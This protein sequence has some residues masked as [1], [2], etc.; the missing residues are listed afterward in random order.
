M[1]ALQQSLLAQFPQVVF[2]RLL[3]R[4]REDGEKPLL[5]V[6][7]ER[8]AVGNFLAAPDRFFLVGEEFIDL[9]GTTNVELIAG[10]LETVGIG[11]QAARVDAQKHVVGDGVGLVQ[12][13]SVAGGHQ[14]QPEAVGDVDGPLGTLLLDGQTVVLDLDVII[15]AKELVEPLGDPACLV[16]AILEDVIAKLGRGTTAED[17]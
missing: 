8:T 5:E 7:L 14:G 11:A 2:R 6:Q 15:V 9:L 4:R 17:R 13:M 10:E 16:Q 12:I 1:V 3:A